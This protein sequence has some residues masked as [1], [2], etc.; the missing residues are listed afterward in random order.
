[1]LE[2][3]RARL[4]SFVHVPDDELV[5]VQNATTG[6][7]IVLHN[8]EWKA[9]DVILTC[10]TT[11]NAVD[12]VAT[13]LHD[14]PP[15]PH[16]ESFDIRLPC[17]S[18]TIVEGYRKHLRELRERVGKAPR[19]VAII[20][21]IISNPGILLPWKELVKACKEFDVLTVVDGAHSVGQELNLELVKVAPDFFISVRL[22]CS[23]HFFLI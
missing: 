3:V 8:L 18:S 21:S 9:E 10:S 17:R 14:I 19:I 7:N 23:S 5:I 2:D 1:M 12:A 4:A 6:I 16:L 22:L 11:Y 20:D 13:Y 15:Y